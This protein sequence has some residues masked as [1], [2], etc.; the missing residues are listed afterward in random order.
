M[1]GNSR[2]TLQYR[3]GGHA[4]ARS[5]H[6]NMCASYRNSRVRLSHTGGS[7]IRHWKKSTSLY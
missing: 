6:W 4:G 2:R 7:T 1:Y 5:Y 3:T